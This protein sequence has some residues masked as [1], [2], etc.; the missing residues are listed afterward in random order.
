MSLLAQYTFVASALMFS[1]LALH[2]LRHSSL[3][4]PVS[5]GVGGIAMIVMGYVSA[6]MN[7]ASTGES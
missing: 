5:S 7:A 2:L 6:M 4:F 1:W 3:S